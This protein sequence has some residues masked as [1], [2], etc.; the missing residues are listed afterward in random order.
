MLVGVP[1]EGSLGTREDRQHYSLAYPH[2]K[3]SGGH[4][5]GQEH[6]V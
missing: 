1:E 2:R 6:V 5:R 4:G 3:A